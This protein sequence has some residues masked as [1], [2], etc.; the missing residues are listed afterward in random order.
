[1]SHLLLPRSKI[2]WISACDK[3]IFSININ[4]GWLFVPTHLRCCGTV[5]ESIKHHV[6]S[7]SIVQKFLCLHESV[8]KHYSRLW[9]H[10]TALQRSCYVSDAETTSWEMTPL[11]NNSEITQEARRNSTV[12]SRTF[13]ISEE[14]PGGS[15]LHLRKVS[16]T[17]LLN[18]FCFWCVHTITL[19]L[20]VTREVLMK[21]CLAGPGG[22]KMF[23]SP[24]MHNHPR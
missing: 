23:P 13:E 1:M 10:L 8:A 3:S 20:F 9:L 6:S 21:L 15:L 22:Q 16:V 14:R 12:T 19:L 18:C 4:I 11:Q 7:Q 17:L 2:N 24:L 5:L